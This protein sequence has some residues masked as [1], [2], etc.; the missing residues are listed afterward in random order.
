MSYEFKY[1]KDVDL[2]TMRQDAEAWVQRQIALERE[3]MRLAQNQA[4][5]EREAKAEAAKQEKL[6]E[7]QN[8]KNAQYERR[9]KI[10]EDKLELAIR[11]EEHWND[12][13][14]SIRIDIAGLNGYIDYM[15]ARGL[16]CRG[17]EEERKKL[18]TKLYNVETKAIKA[19]QARE[20]CELEM[21]Y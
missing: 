16:S 19:R 20:L 15:K 3:Q 18:S 6:W 10:L 2:A 1:G 17:K 9:L 4:R 12:E 21:K 8:K 13:A 14:Q 7:E 5:L 11:D